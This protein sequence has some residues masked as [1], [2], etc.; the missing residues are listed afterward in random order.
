MAT[1]AELPGGD[2]ILVVDDEPSVRTPIVRSLRMKGY[3]VLEANN[4]EHALQVMQEHRAPV[5]LVISD[6]FMPEMKGTELAALLR[7]WYPG[8]RVL[9][10][11]GYSPEHIDSIGD[12]SIEGIHLLAKPFSL[13]DLARRVREVLESDWPQQ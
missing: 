12:E 4:G 1:E 13:D 6:V 10:I 2:V 11:S 3:T 8:M 7:S 5:H 9:F